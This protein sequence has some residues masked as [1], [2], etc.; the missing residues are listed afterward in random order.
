MSSSLIALE[1][2]DLRLVSVRAAPHPLRRPP[3]PEAPH[4]RHTERTNGTDLDRGYI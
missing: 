2:S 4:R 3:S 1:T